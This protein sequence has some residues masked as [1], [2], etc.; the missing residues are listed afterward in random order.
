[1]KCVLSFDGKIKIQQNMKFGP[2]EGITKSTKKLMKFTDQ[3]QIAYN[4]LWLQQ[5]TAS[6]ILKVSESFGTENNFW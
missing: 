5:K 1:M 2:V 6:K 4:Y 3:W